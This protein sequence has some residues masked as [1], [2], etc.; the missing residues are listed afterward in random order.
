MP[1]R[2]LAMRLRTANKKRK[3]KAKR[4]LLIANLKAKIRR[5]LLDA[6]YE[7]LAKYYREQHTKAWFGPSEPVGIVTMSPE[8]MAN[9]K[10]AN[11]LQS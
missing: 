11:L 4:D 3:R 9:V 6:Y 1:E 5:M 8:F 2:L 10:G 7:E